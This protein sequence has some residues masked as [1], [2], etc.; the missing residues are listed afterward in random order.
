MLAKI[1]LTVDYQQNITSWIPYKKN[2][3]TKISTK[4]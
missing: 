4:R 3:R 2:V 1:Y